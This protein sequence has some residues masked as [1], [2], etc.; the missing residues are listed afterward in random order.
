M[1]ASIRASKG[2]PSREQRYIAECREDAA[3]WVLSHVLQK[4]EGPM[5]AS[6]T[7]RYENFLKEKKKK[8]SSEMENEKSGIKE[9][10]KAKK[11]TQW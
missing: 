1:R 10:V 11:A 6:K 4:G 9:E 5:K 2:Q 8:G 7:L 3:H